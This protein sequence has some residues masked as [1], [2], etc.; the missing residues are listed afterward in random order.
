[1]NNLNYR[2]C[3]IIMK[4]IFRKSNIFS[5]LLGAV[6]FGGITV[7]SAYTIFAN[8]IE[9]TPKDTAWKKSDGTDITNVKEAIDELYIKSNYNNS[10]CSD[11]ILSFYLNSKSDGYPSNVDFDVKK[12]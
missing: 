9:Y 1:M 4:K 3:E 5:F 12:L 6:M 11:I 8:D 2:Y 7:V 10:E